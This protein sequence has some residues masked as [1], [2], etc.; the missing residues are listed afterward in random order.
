MN[1]PNYTTGHAAFTPHGPSPTARTLIPPTRVCAE[2]PAVK[3][4]RADD[5]Q[6]PCPFCGSRRIVKG[7]R[8]FAMCVD[9]G[10]TGPERSADATQRKFMGDWNTRASA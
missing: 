5:A 9:C 3:L 4:P 10:A 8:Y 6:K 1:T 2:M 7:E